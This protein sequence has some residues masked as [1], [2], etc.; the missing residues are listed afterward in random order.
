MYFNILII[1]GNTTIL[2]QAVGKQNLQTTKTFP[3]L[4]FRFVGIVFVLG[5]DSFKI[6][7]VGYKYIAWLAL[8][9]LP[10]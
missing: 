8:A 6:R 3:N 5:I 9:Q 7:S 10:F 4:C 2:R 1:R